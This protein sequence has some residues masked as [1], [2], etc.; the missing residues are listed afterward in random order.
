M[1]QHAFAVSVDIP[2]PGGEKRAKEIK[3]WFMLSIDFEYSDFCE[4]IIIGN[5]DV[6]IEIFRETGTFAW[7]LEMLIDGKPVEWPHVF[8][9]DKAAYDAAI[10]YLKERGLNP[11]MFTDDDDYPII[12]SP[13][14][15]KLLV[16]G[17]PFEISIYRGVD[18]PEWILEITNAKGTSIIPDE[19]FKTDE[20]ALGV[21]LADFE[22]E[23]I[24]NFLV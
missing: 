14:C 11:D 20:D 5:H 13:L 15:Q 2:K 18:E 22:N 10:L 1:L 21:A 3:R 8:V 4:S 7:T 12:E 9:A 17:H 16:E 19:R 6:D 24:A 23:P